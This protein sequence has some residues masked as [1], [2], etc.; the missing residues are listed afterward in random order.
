VEQTSDVLL[1]LEEGTYDLDFANKGLDQDEIA[2]LESIDSIEDNCKSVK[3]QIHGEDDCCE[4]E[5]ITEDSD[6]VETEVEVVEE[7]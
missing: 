3:Q 7:V 2:I 4:D 6:D 1:E 5:D